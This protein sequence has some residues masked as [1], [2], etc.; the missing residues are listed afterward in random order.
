MCVWWSEGISIFLIRS[1][2]RL[3]NIFFWFRD[4]FKKNFFVIQS[5]YL[6]LY[7]RCNFSGEFFFHF[8]FNSDYRIK[9]I[10]LNDSTVFCFNNRKIN[11]KRKSLPVNKSISL[12]NTYIYICYIYAE[13]YARSWTYKIMHTH[14]H[15]NAFNKINI[16]STPQST[17]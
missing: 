17:F 14:S 1:T 12:S 13:R 9:N 11:N 3:K 4:V 8:Q 15:V 5:F 2:K 7:C 10:K 16:K 6:L